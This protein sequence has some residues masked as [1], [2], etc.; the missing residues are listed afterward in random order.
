MSEFA[1]K[2]AIVTGASSG[3]GRATAL[4]LA[5][6][7]AA[8]VVGDYSDEGGK[9]TAKLIADAGGKAV[10]VHVDVSNEAEVKAMVDAAITNYGRLD[11]LV[12]N[13]GIAAAGPPVPLHEVELTAFEK[14]QDINVSGVFLGTKHAVPH[15][16]KSGGGSIVNVSSVAGAR[17][18]PGDPS[19]CTSKHAL[20]GF[21]KSAAL[22]YAKQGIRVNAIGPGVVYTAMTKFIT[23][24]EGASAGMLAVTPMGRFATPEEMAKPIAFL[25]SDGASYITGTYY[26]IDGG[27]LAG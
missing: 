17:G 25:L 2:V 12:N 15:M 21:T 13:A 4:E 7:G 22:T 23:D 11:Y 20:I 18:F 3:I 14:V 9:E 16:L 1:G 5:K 27:W 6:R 26:N 8:V 10:F 24:D 19:Y